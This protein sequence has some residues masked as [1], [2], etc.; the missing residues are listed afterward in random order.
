MSLNGQHILIDIRVNCILHPNIVL[1]V[2]SDLVLT[3]SFC[4]R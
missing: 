4:S 2:V 3:Y 1:N